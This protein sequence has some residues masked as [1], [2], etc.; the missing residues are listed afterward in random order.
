MDGSVEEQG[1]IGL[2]RTGQDGMMDETGWDGV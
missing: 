1:W 2:N